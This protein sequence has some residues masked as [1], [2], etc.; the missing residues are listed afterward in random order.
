MPSPLLQRARFKFVFVA[1]LRL[2]TAFAVPVF[3]LSIPA[4]GA[5]QSVGVARDL[6]PEVFGALSAMQAS[7]ASSYNEEALFQLVSRVWWDLEYSEAER[8]LVRELG[9]VQRPITC[10][11]T[12]GSTLEFTLDPTPDAARQQRFL[13]PLS[14]G[15]GES[16]YYVQAFRRTKDASLFVAATRV[17]PNAREIMADTLKVMINEARFAAK[18]G[19]KRT[20]ADLFSALQAGYERANPD[21]R[22]EF[23]ATVRAIVAQFAEQPGALPPEIV[24]APW[25]QVVP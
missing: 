18:S 6:P 3:N 23:A 4:L 16:T 11:S 14:F 20:L 17:H 9:R 22:E 21:H 19:N 2:C 8:G 5:E 15:P 7:G 24:R 25:L 13:L 10:I 12:D 1:S